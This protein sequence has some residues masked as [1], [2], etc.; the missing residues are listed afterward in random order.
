MKEI[1]ETGYEG[2]VLRIDLSTGEIS[3]ETVDAA[4]MRMFVGGT[5]LGAK[6]L[7]EEVPPGV[8]WSDPGNRLIVGS[9]PLGGTKI[10]GSGTI[11]IVTKGPLTNGATSTQA[12]GFLGAFMRL[13]G[14]DSIVFQGA[15]DKLVYLLIA[16]G[17]AE[18]RDASHLAGKDTWETQDAIGEELGKREREISVF[19][20]G[21][22]GENL[23]KFAAVAGDKGHVAGHNG[24]GAVM[25][26][27]RLKAIAI[28]RGRGRIKVA[29]SHALA[30]AGS[31][32]IDVLKSKPGSFDRWDWG[33][34]MAFIVAEKG[35]WLP[36]KNYTTNIFPDTEPFMAR[37]YR[38][39]NKI[40]PHPCW[41]CQMH[42]LHMI[43]IGK[44]P[45]AGY[46]GEEPEH[47]QWAA[48]APVIGNN[49][50]A[51]ALVLA[52]DTDRLG[53][54]NNEAGW[55]IGW[56]MECFEKGL[57]TEEQTDGLKMTWGNVEATRAMLKKIARRDGVGNLLA[58]GVMRAS[59]R[60]GGEAADL[61]IYTKKGNSPRG[62][63]HRAK[64]SEMLDTC[65]SNT[66]T[67][68]NGGWLVM[69]QDIGLKET[70]D[71]S[72]EEVSTILAKSKGRMV[73]ED[74]LGACR[75][76]LWTEMKFVTEAVN[77]AT[78]WNMDIVEG[79][80][81]GKRIV[82]LLRAF[83][84]RHGITPEVEA[85]SQRYGSVPVDGPAQGRNIA[86]EWDGM[87]DNY[88]N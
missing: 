32:I 85:P 3:T 78:G 7:Y 34:G 58:E 4:T 50:P 13:N 5:G 51:G 61:A 31:A 60:I 27:K 68:E 44:G 86:P 28:V 76:C 84:V 48:W 11:S 18:I 82:N 17:K 49:D 46:V 9:G 23:V 64:W 39:E 59:Q 73:F 21:P 30:T 47:E 1:G 71:F 54:E 8:E 26:S 12:N 41:A 69:G 81:V 62:H 38:T 87:M 33:T 52:N 45:Y 55:V 36:T 67:I 15:A 20:I 83:N 43:T 77:A 80:D 25:G 56:V 75:F 22:A 6:I 16:D 70:D 63:D 40:K 53:F 14:Y 65:V 57:F 74:C 42:H 66:G 2:R 10:M 35:G 19:S 79:Y 24:S 29:N 37:N 72:A 88:Y